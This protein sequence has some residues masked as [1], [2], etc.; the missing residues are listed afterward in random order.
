MHIDAKP[1]GALEA[2]DLLGEC[3]KRHKAEQDSPRGLTLRRL[4]QIHSFSIPVNAANT[5]QLPT[6]YLLQTTYL[7][8]PP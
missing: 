1:L 6:A 5:S 3:L 8:P 2:L 7:L 4:S